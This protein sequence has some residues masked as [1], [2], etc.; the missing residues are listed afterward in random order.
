MEGLRKREDVLADF[1]NKGRSIRGWAIANELDPSVVHGV[2]NGR[3][4]GRIGEAH[5]AAVKLGLKHGEIV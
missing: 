4:K 3:L 2:L 1:I 5:K